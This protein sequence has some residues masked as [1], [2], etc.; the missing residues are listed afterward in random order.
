MPDQEG[1][2]GQVTRKIKHKDINY[3]NSKDFLLKG[4]GIIMA[5]KGRG[6]VTEQDLSERA[7]GFAKFATPTMQGKGKVRA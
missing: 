6:A 3:V 2:R 4:K 1:A 5:D 7:V